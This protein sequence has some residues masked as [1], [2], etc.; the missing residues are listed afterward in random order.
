MDTAPPISTNRSRATVAAAV[1]TFIVTIPY[2]YAA[3]DIGRMAFGGA[4]IHENLHDG[5]IEFGLE[6]TEYGTVMAMSA[7]ALISTAVYVAAIGVGILRRREWARYGGILTFL[8]FGLILLPLAIS[9]LTYDPPSSNAW[10]GV[11]L[12]L[13]EFSIVGLLL[14]SAVSDD[15]ETA[16][17]M[18]KRVERHREMRMRA[19]ERAL[20]PWEDFS[21]TANRS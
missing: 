7:I 10:F 16:D 3:I 21:R 19:R 18:R 13:T 11:L 1:V 4:P 15:F 20:Q 6:P 8:F 5:M 12:A 14:L 2:A 9:G 17:W